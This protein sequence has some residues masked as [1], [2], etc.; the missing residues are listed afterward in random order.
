MN[1]NESQTEPLKILNQTTSTNPL[2]DSGIQ[3][4]IQIE[5]VP[6]TLSS[7]TLNSLSNWLKKISPMILS[8]LKFNE[9]SNVFD[10]DV[11]SED[12]EQDS[13]LSI[14]QTICINATQ[15]VN[16]EL[17][18]A[19]LNLDQSNMNQMPIIGL[20][21]NSIGYTLAAASGY[22]YHESWCEHIGSIFV[23][24]KKSNA[25]DLIAIYETKMSSCITVIIFHPKESDLLA[26]ATVSGEISLYNISHLNDGSNREV[27]LCSESSSHTGKCISSLLWL[28]NEQTNKYLMKTFSIT[29][30][31]L[32]SGGSDGKVIIW[33]VNLSTSSISKNTCFELYNAMAR[34]TNLLPD[35]SCVDFYHIFKT[36]D[37]MFLQSDQSLID[38]EDLDDYFAVGC[39]TGELLLCRTSTARSFGTSNLDPCV[40]NLEA[41]KACILNLSFSSTKP[42]ILLT[43]GADQEI[44][45]Y[46]VI[47]NSPIQI[48]YLDNEFSCIKWLPTSGSSVI[49]SASKHTDL[50]PLQVFNVDTR[51]EIALKGFVMDK[52]ADVNVGQSTFEFHN[53]EHNLL[54]CGDVCGKIS[55]MKIPIKNLQ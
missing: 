18:T 19:S 51:R 5:S 21:W 44:R 9:T 16:N 47:V 13:K 24:S 39:K 33:I 54:A 4:D 40:G 1:D 37:K 12:E 6:Q 2:K 30:K 42:R 55:I 29:E 48:I 14:V 36:S 53:R 17:G 15:D 49:V 3:S 45:I 8:E 52:S 7:S 38:R 25:K 20:S 11:S 22:L 27:L 35:I 23:Y 28:N 31:I 32:V 34:K 41:H 26:V 46:D 43:L 10:D 50:F